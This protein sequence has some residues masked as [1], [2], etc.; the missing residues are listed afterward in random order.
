[1]FCWKNKREVMDL[2]EG[3]RVDKVNIKHKNIKIKGV[4]LKNGE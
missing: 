1:M 3:N 2:K 4:I